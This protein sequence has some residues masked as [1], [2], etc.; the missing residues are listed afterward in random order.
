MKSHL[1]HPGTCF[2]LVVPVFPF[3]SI[4]IYLIYLILTKDFH[5]KTKFTLLLLSCFFALGLQAQISWSDDLESYN[6]GDFI[7]VV[8][9]DWTTWSNMPGSTQDAQVSDERAASGT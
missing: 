1:C 5:M 3:C 9:Q 2:T 4:L 8:S 7:D 6:V